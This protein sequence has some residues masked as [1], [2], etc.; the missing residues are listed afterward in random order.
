MWLEFL[1]SI[2]TLILWISP[3]GDPD[4]LQWAQEWPNMSRCWCTMFEPIVVF[5]GA[6]L[7]LNLWCFQIFYI[8]Y[9]CSHLF[10]VMVQIYIYIFRGVET[11]NETTNIWVSWPMI[12]FICHDSI[13]KMWLSS[14]CTKQLRSWLHFV[15][16]QIKCSIHQH[17]QHWMMGNLQET[18]FVQV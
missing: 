5:V 16:G 1:G 7:L 13:K 14:R 8:I 12:F 18:R 6:L 17:S 2:L 11:T 15:D 10:R 4:P 9:L 3:L